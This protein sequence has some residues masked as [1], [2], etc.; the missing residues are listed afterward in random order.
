MG[1]A[2]CPTNTST[3]YVARNWG[4]YD[5]PTPTLLVPRA[6]PSH[7]SELASIK[8]MFHLPTLRYFQTRR[9]SRRRVLLDTQQRA[10][11]VRERC[12][13][14]IDHQRARGKNILTREQRPA[15]VL[16]LFDCGSTRHEHCDGTDPP[17]RATKRQS[18]KQ[19]RCRRTTLTAPLVENDGPRNPGTRTIA[20]PSYSL[21][22][23]NTD[24][25]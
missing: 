22:F 20:P 16:L 15:P 4:G 18:E 19:N 2:H 24:T 6:F 11:R 21:A 8:V 5:L 1:C 14:Q 12:A 17:R 13:T 10:T 3:S 23:G 9:A 25:R 7:T